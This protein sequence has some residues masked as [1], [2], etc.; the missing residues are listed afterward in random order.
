MKVKEIEE[1]YQ[2]IIGQLEFC[3]MITSI[4]IEESKAS[5]SKKTSDRCRELAGQIVNNVHKI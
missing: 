3:E 2:Y 4:F 5:I 1:Y